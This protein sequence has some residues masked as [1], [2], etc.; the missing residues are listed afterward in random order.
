MF[1]EPFL[2]I[3][4]AAR[5]ILMLLAATLSQAPPRS[6]MVK[7]CK[8]TLARKAGGDVDK[9]TVASTTT[10]RSGTMLTGRLT[11]FV[12]AAPASPGSASPHHLIR[13]DYGFECLVRH[14]RIRRARLSQP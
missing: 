6:D 3:S 1:A 12:G 7:L 5:M 11:V 2:R 10:S 9:L 14:G 4:V 8:A 13:A